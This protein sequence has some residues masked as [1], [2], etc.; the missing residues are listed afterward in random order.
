MTSCGLVNSV[1][2]ETHRCEKSQILNLCVSPASV[3]RG[4]FT[5][6]E[7]DAKSGMNIRDSEKGDMKLQSFT[8]MTAST[9]AS[10]YGN[11]F[12]V[13]TRRKLLVL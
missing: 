8:H 7:K 11:V 3:E 9:C 13:V 12:A 6:S 10:D 2:N 1:S 5:G 4:E